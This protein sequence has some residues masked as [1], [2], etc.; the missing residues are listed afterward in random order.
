MSFATLFATLFSI[1]SLIF[2]IRIVGYTAV[3]KLSFFELI[4]LYLFM[5]PRIILFT[6]PFSFFIALT[7]TLF[8]LSKESETTVIFAL[9]YSP[10]KMTNFFFKISLIISVFLVIDAM[11]LLPLISKQ[12]YKKFINYKK[13]EAKLNIK[14]TEFGQKYG[15]W[16]VY[17]NVKN[18]ENDYRDIVMFKNGKDRGGDSFIIAKSAKLNKESSYL[19][20]RLKDGKV[21]NFSE[22]KLEEITY[23]GL[24][25]NMPTKIMN[26]KTSQIVEYWAIAFKDTKRFY[27][28]VIYLLISLFP[29]LSFKIAF[30]IGLVH[31]REYGVNIYPKIFYTIGG[32]LILGYLIGKFQIFSFFALFIFAFYIFAQI[33]F[34]KK[35]LTRY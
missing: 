35:V 7:T 11:V 19:E 14:A 12:M 17:I 24:R 23:G 29:F 33:V 15:D 4:Q 26:F 2:F 6:M 34:N 16:L 18:G 22:K 21:Y 1:L 28:L 5:V 25:I 10:K 3:I 20:F 31:S 8:R 13:V 32:Y 30:M 9:G 27:D